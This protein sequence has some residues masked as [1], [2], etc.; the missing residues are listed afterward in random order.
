[1]RI[2]SF[3]LELLN[4]CFIIHLYRNVI[5]LSRRDWVLKLQK[6]KPHWKNAKSLFANKENRNKLRVNKSITR[7]FSTDTF[8][9]TTNTKHIVVFIF[10]DY[11]YMG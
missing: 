4:N 9:K 8:N 10:I 3:I 1:M 11:K 6:V 2:D 5:Q 7:P